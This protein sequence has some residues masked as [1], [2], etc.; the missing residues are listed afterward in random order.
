MSKILGMQS[1]HTHGALVLPPPL[2]L[3]RSLS[4]KI[5]NASSFYYRLLDLCLRLAPP[6]SRWLL[7]KGPRDLPR[8][9]SK[10]LAYGRLVL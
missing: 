3:F 2:T 5:S 4:S 1:A 8:P 9:S 10:R 6:V 7:K